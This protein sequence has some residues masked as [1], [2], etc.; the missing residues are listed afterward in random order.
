[1]VKKNSDQSVQES[2]ESSIQPP[3]NK[4]TCCAF[5]LIALIILALFLIGGIISGIIAW[6]AYG[7]ILMETFT[8]NMT[9]SVT[10]QLSDDLLPSVTPFAR[11]NTPTST[12]IQTTIIE[13]TAA[14]QQ[15]SGMDGEILPESNIRNLTRGD[16]TG[17]TAWELKVARNE[18]Y[19]R[20]GRPFVHQDLA[21][22]F[23]TMSWYKKDPDYTDSR[24]SSL[25][26]RNAV[27]ILNYEKE[28][29]SP[30]WSVD[31]GC[32]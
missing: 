13:P 26:Q 7:P 20:H 19:A 1:M 29:G 28:T 14:L 10:K 17:L 22:Y 9:S 30:I 3:S 24:L 11:E 8:K 32:R 5:A 31:T 15:T 4:N 23:T 12:P 6:K 16:L 25:E 18:I 27:F 21:C 2:T